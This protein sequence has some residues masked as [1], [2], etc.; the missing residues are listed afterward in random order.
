[1][2]PLQTRAAV[3]HHEKSKDYDSVMDIAKA[4]TIEAEQQSW[5]EPN[6]YVCPDKVS[7]KTHEEAQADYAG[8]IELR[9][10]HIE[11]NTVIID[12]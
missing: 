10:L 7:K 5:Y 12:A 9:C 1:M 3:I 8:L 4:K 6:Y 2:H 11:L